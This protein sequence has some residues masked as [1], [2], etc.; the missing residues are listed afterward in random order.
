MEAASAL[1][2]DEGVDSLRLEHVARRAGCSRSSLYRYFDTK[3]AVIIAVLQKRV[4]QMATRIR[5]QLSDTQHPADKIVQGVVRAVELALS[6]PQFSVLFSAPNSPTV[7]RIA[8]NALPQ[9]ITPVIDCI[10][11]EEGEESWF[12]ESVP[13][14][15]AARWLVTVVVGLVTFD[16]ERAMDHDAFVAHLERFLV[17]SLLGAV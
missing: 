14:A 15:E 2:V 13:V 7:M 3:D 11:P 17:P 10:L 5:I 9:L 16:A 4:D 1:M 12:P 8:A 6:D